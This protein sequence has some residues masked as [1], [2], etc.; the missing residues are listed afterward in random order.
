MSAWYP[1]HDTDHDGRDNAKLPKQG[2]HGRRVDAGGW[3]EKSLAARFH[4]QKLETER[5]A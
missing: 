3:G 1:P 5:M 2:L 4:L